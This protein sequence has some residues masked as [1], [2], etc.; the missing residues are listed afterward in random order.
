MIE[1]TSY[2]CSILSMFEFLRVAYIAIKQK[3]IIGYIY[4]AAFDCFYLV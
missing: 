1:S 3:K 4:E 2:F